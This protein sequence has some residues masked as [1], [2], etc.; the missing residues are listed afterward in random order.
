MRFRRSIKIFPGVKLNLGK[1][2]LTSLTVFKRG[3]SL[4]A[5]ARGSHLNVGL[6]GTGLS[7]RIRLDAPTKAGKTVK[8]APPV[9]A[10]AG[11]TPE[12]VSPRV[13]QV[14]G[15]PESF[16][17]SW[18]RDPAPADAG[19]EFDSSAF[20][21]AVNQHRLIKTPPA[22]PR[23]AY[24]SFY[25][26]EPAYPALWVSAAVLSTSAFI[27]ALA[28]QPAAWALLGSAAAFL[29]SLFFVRAGLSVRSGW[30]K[31]E[32]RKKE[33]VDQALS[34]HFTAMEEIFFQALKNMD[35]MFETSASF[36]ISRDGAGMVI[37]VNL[38]EIEDLERAVPPPGAGSAD[39][40]RP[41]KKP[42][43]VQREYQLLVHATVLRLAG[44][45]FYYF[46]TLDSV[47][48]SGYT[49]RIDRRTGLAR[50]E[51]VISVDFDRARWISINPAQADPV[52][53]VGLFPVR[54]EILSDSSLKSIEPFTAGSRSAVS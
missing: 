32:L 25:A 53:C 5:G 7:H 45:V 35:W 52:E 40:G 42:W 41:G 29:T 50:P 21:S 17:P 13:L 4:T 24:A 12:S 3:L 10:V 16:R 18:E 20:D 44:E 39:S 15:G 51:Y 36:E 6:P 27:L 30:K 49:D 22:E 47:L 19:N 11:F 48:A 2:G 31:E 28:L 54:R 33:L 46:P 8:R 37:D 43:M 14:Q 23:D 38:P 34:G 1:S 9:S 26:P